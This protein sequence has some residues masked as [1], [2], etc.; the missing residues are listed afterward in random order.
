MYIK[1]DSSQF[2][3][4]RVETGYNRLQPVAGL[5]KTAHNRFCAVRSG[6]IY[7]LNIIEPVAVP[8]RSQN[9]KKPDRA[10]PLNA[11]RW[12]VRS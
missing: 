10:G 3:L 11:S 7:F 5:H 8:V 9:G 2:R 12:F 4:T 1:V 6:F